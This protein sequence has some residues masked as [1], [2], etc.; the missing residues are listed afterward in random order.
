ML[1][2]LA[3][4]LLLH[5]AP[6]KAAPVPLAPPRPDWVDSLPGEPGRL[7]ALGTSDLGGSQS[8]ALRRASD[9]ARV[10][11]VSRLRTSVKGSTA[12]VT[13][14]STVKVDGKGTGY[15]S[16]DVR[17]TV[18][19]ST[20][21]EDLPGL[22]VER[23]FIDPASKTAFALGCLDLGQARGTLN[24]RLQSAKDTRQRLSKEQTRKARW[25]LRKVKEDLDRLEELVN[26]LAAAGTGDL[27]PALNAER[28]AVDKRLAQLEAAN[29][30]ALNLKDLSVSLRCNI[31]L[32]GTLQDYLEAQLRLY[33]FRVRP[34]GGG[35]FILDL[36][37][38]GTEKGPEFLFADIIF[39]GGVLYRVEAK[40]RV[41][42]NTGILLAQG[43]AISL[44]Q[45]DSP[46]GLTDKFR[47]QYERRLAYLLADLEAELR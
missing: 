16:R 26:M 32:P 11:V 18:N 40:M 8:E 44:V 35:D 19:V 15:G 27:R 42:D 23:T 17:D 30:P 38:T 5:A 36:S 25:R 41:L 46:S 43:S 29:L 20:Q 7:Y 22:S 47:R 6:P 45:P 1:A 3:F 39:A 24:E 12:I 13:K 21:A 4:S 31:D 34:A 9:R 28:E 33:G 10:E 37:F 14:S 2:A